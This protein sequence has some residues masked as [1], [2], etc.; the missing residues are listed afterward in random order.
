MHRYNYGFIV[1]KGLMAP[2]GWQAALTR[3]GPLLLIAA[4]LMVAFSAGL[5]N[6][7]GD[8]QFMLGAVLAS[9]IAPALLS[10]GVSLGITLSL[11]LMA[12]ALGGVLWGLLPAVLK[13]WRN[14]NEIITS[15]MMSFLGVSLAN[16]LVKLLLAD[17]ATTVPQTRNLPWEQRLPMLFGGQVSSGLLLGLLAIV[18]VHAVINHTA[19]GLRLR[20]MGANLRAAIH[21]GLPVGALTLAVFALSAGLAGAVEIIGIQGNVRADWNPAYSLVVVPLVFL[22]Q[23][24]GFGS[25][26]LVFVFSVLSIGSESAAR[27]MDVPNHFTLLTV[28]LL[29][30][31]P[32]LTRL[33]VAR[34]RQALR[35]RVL[36]NTT[37][38]GA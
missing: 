30:I 20:V 3:M 31:V 5:W 2:S 38:G 25:I 22:A 13:I 15:L 26:A 8:G 27:R 29:L 11:A 24:N 14:I 21:A 16:V 1:R 18:L 28:A 36:R 19:F 12:G 23:F 4:S 17:P 32:G 7:G 34:L 10:H 6:L 33:A 37:Q 9:A 35:H